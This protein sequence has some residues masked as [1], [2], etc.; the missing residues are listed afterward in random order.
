MQ[1]IGNSRC[2][3]RNGEFDALSMSAQIE[4]EGENC[5][6]QC[7]QCTSWYHTFCV[8]FQS[9]EALPP[10]DVEWVCPICAGSLRPEAPAHAEQ[11]PAAASAAATAAHPSLAERRALC[12]AAAEG[13]ATATAQCSDDEPVSTRRVPVS[14]RT[15][16]KRLMQK[17]KER[18]QATAKKV[19]CAEMC[20]C[21]KGLHEHGY[22]PT[23]N[24]GYRNGKKIS[25]GSSV[26]KKKKVVGRG[27]AP[28]DDKPQGA[29]GKKRA[30]RKKSKTNRITA[31]DAKGAMDAL[32]AKYSRW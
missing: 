9:R 16:E 5:S 19:A 6:I 26:A 3:W 13:R 24:P 17:K 10:E 15:V 28:K 8:G 14:T 22:P 23:C 32:L 11:S 25:T 18:I 21:G 20:P 1:C 4:L 30:T 7:D 2:K 29:I 12:A 31:A 27:G